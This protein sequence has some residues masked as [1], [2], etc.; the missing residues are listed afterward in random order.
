MDQGSEAR[1][2]QGEQE[3]IDQADHINL[4]RMAL[5]VYSQEGEAAMIVFLAD[6]REPQETADARKARSMELKD[7]AE[8][9]IADGPE[10]LKI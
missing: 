5:D 3:G 10:G 2:Q 4:A 6:N 7:G 8:V 9:E 1:R